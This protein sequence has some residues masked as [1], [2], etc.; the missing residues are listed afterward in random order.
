MFHSLNFTIFAE[1]CQFLA[2]FMQGTHA[3]P[4]CLVR[5]WF[6]I[7]IF[8]RSNSKPVGFWIMHGI[9]LFCFVIHT[10][11]QN[12]LEWRPL[13]LAS[14]ISACIDKLWFSNIFEK[15]IAHVFSP[16]GAVSTWKSNESPR[17]LVLF[18]EP[19]FD[20]CTYIRCEREA[21]STQLRFGLKTTR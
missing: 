10:W 15:P 21:W 18:L 20:V 8:L 2:S 7:Q 13:W 3:H 19:C 12:G 4:P 9:W 17:S 11:C 6:R 14:F 16:D 1:C 5:M